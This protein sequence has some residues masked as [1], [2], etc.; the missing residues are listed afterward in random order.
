MEQRPFKPV[1]QTCDSILLQQV[2]V[3]FHFQIPFHVGGN[4]KICG[5]QNCYCLKIKIKNRVKRK[6]STGEL[7]LAFLFKGKK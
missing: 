6:S 4:G 1:A 7:F 5:S 2:A 3:K